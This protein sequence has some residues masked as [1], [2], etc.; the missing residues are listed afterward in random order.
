[1]KKIFLAVLAIA[2]V[3]CSSKPTATILKG[4]VPAEASDKVAVAIPDIQFDTVVTVSDGAFSL[5]LPVNKMVIGSVSAG[6]YEAR[7]VPDG[8]TLTLVWPEDEASELAIRSSSKKSVTARL[9]AVDEWMAWFFENY[10]NAEDQDAEFD[11]YVAKLKEIV[12]DNPD[13]V[14]GLL[15]VTSLRGQIDAAELM[16]I[17]SSVSPEIQENPGVAKMK[18]ALESA[19]ST[20]EGSMFTDFEVEQPDGSVKKLSDYVG[21]GKY[22]LADFWASWCGPC[23]RE[24]PNIK[25][26]YAKYHGE[27]FDVLSIAVWDKPEDTARA[28]AEEKLPWPQIV[29]AQRIPT[30][31]Y[32]IQGIPHLILFGPDGTILQ[33]GES[34]RGDNM[35]PA[36]GR[37]V[38]N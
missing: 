26:A 19:L 14:L 9:A 7:F 30:D 16:E 32:G 13:N 22:I 31:I 24:I 36:I 25:A 34:L 18:A 1:M 6:G 8:T 2:A 11:K 27:N 38:G 33:R 20:G 12:K 37:Y 23:R 29:N 21:K 3:A 28:L 10:P 4:S 15:G 35:D 5:S 17:I